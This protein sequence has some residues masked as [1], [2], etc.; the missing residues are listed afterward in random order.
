MFYFWFTPDIFEVFGVLLGGIILVFLYLLVFGFYFVVGV[1]ALILAW[2]VLHGIF[3]WT[4][5]WLYRLTGKGV[6]PKKV[7][8]W[9]DERA[10]KT[11]EKL[12]KIKN[13]DNI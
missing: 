3:Y 13:E 4:N 11:N 8:K 7:D 2:G 6:D 5:Y 10:K 9:M 12:E 1:L